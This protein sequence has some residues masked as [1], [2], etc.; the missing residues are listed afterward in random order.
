MAGKGNRLGRGSSLIERDA[1]RIRP[2]LDGCPRRHVGRV[3]RC[4]VGGEH[5]ALEIGDA[6]VG[7][8]REAKAEVSAGLSGQCAISRVSDKSD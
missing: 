6:R 7:E 2:N 3:G 4:G 8:R 1:E 5:R